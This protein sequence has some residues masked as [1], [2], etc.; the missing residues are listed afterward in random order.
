VSLFCWQWGSPAA[1][2]FTS[3]FSVTYITNQQATSHKKRR[4]KL[5]IALHGKPISEL[6]DV[7]C[8]MGSHSVTCHPTQVNTPRLNP[9]QYAGTRFTYPGGME[10]W[11]DL[12]YPVMHRPGVELAISR[13]QVRDRKSDALTTTPPS[14]PVISSDITVIN[15]Q[16]TNVLTNRPQHLHR[17]KQVLSTS[18]IHIFNLA[19]M[20]IT[21]WTYSIHCARPVASGFDE[22]NQQSVYRPFK[23]VDFG[24]NWK[25]IYDFLL[26]TISD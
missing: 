15:L 5:C 17:H 7:T 9:S 14:R 13:S 2:W 12:G 6:R 22:L 11:V 23:V 8:H 21:L 18:I 25:G 3:R 19:N 16:H 20:N 26:V 4:L 1:G 24:T 10:G